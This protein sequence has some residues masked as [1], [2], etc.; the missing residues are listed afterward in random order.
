MK[1]LFIAIG[2][3]MIGGAVS[4]SPAAHAEPCAAL[5]CMAGMPATG[6]GCSGPVGEFSVFRYGAF[7]DTSQVQRQQGVP[8]FEL[9]LRGGGQRSSRAEDHRDV[10]DTARCAMTKD[11]VPLMVAHV[12]RGTAKADDGMTGR[13]LLVGQC[14]SPLRDDRG[15]FRAK[16]RIELIGVLPA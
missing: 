14:R 10:R 3:A 7:G 6:A 5:L 12:M 2:A 15:E 13:S 11:A 1:R 4:Y 16:G 8:R 9:V